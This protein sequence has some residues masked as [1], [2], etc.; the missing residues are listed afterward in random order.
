MTLICR[1][2]HLGS[3]A[4]K[5]FSHGHGIINF[6]F[7]FAIGLPLGLMALL[8]SHSAIAQDLSHSPQSLASGAGLLALNSREA[9]SPEP[10]C[11]TDDNLRTSTQ[12]T[13]WMGN[14]VK[15]S[16]WVGDPEVGLSHLIQD[17]GPQL[18]SYLNPSPWPQISDRAQ[19]A[20]VPVM[21]YHDILPEKQVFFD[22][23]PEEFEQHLQLIQERGLTPI[24]LDQLTTH[25]RTGLPLPEKPILL[26][27]DDGYKG[28]YEHVYP[29]L[30]KY[31]YPAVFSIYTAKVGKKLGRSSLNW[32]ELRQMATDPLVT[33]AAHSVTHPP[34]LTKLTD[35]HLATEVAESKQLLEAELGMPIRYFTY[36]EGKY[37]QRVAK[38]VQEAGYLAAF[39]MD[40]V[41][42][43]FAGES[44]SLLAIARF[45]QSRLPDIIDQAWG[46]SPLPSWNLGFDFSAPVQLTETTIDE[47]PFRL[48]SGGK[49]I[50]IHAK[51]RYQ[52]QEILEGTQAIAAVDGGFFS[53]RYLDSNVMIGPVMSQSNGQFVPGN[54]S[55]NPRLKGRPLVVMGPQ[56]A[57]FIPF[58]PDKH[59]SL[60]GVQAELAGVT[61]AFVAAAW[62]VK[63][64]QPQPASTFN[65][66][67]DFD[68]VRHRA[69]WGINQTGQPTIGVSV[70]PIDSVSLGIALVKAGFRDAVM[71]DSGASTSLAYKGESLVGYIPRPVPHVVAL[72]PSDA[73]AKAACTLA[74]R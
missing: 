4:A 68:A 72:V 30:K 42:E 54:H 19:Q 43:R 63:D 57:K 58:N 8:W 20:R 16:T 7:R 41:D 15:A 34:D 48:I 51:S 18:I 11:Q 39:T 70:E 3:Q 29:L 33:I 10:V 6:R 71:L 47:T 5:N 21:M 44:E 56:A 46:G 9:Q 32:E 74:S 12:L 52:V 27:F 73:E 22:V 14:L 45:G 31:G 55:D 53:L 49:P 62:L 36:P 50:T 24:S 66:L 2:H 35:D 17:L 1:E 38:V 40:D 13:T 67:F 61:D 37:D 25:L 64:S 23:T 28:H 59:N 26:T 60:E 65:S 69:F